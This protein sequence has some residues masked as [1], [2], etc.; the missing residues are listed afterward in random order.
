MKRLIM[1]VM[2]LSMMTV[3]LNAQ[4]VG[5]G[6]KGGMNFANVSAK[7]ISTSSIT[8][9][10]VGAYLNLYF[11]K[12]IGIVPE[13]QFST[14][15]SDLE[16]DKLNTSYLAIPIMLQIKPVKF[17]HVEAGPQFSFLTKAESEDLGDVKDQLKNNDFGIGF[18]AGVHLPLGLNVGARYVLGFTNISEVSEEEIKNRLFQIY[19]GWTILGNK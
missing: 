2:V 7:D 6:I 12:S 16:G 14:M 4:G 11:S 18:G 3:A 9:Y 17:L 1:A 19:V 5:L 13:V 10:H 15:G 8:S